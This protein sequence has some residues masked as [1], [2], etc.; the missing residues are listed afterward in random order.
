[1]SAQLASRRMVEARLK[2]H[3]GRRTARTPI[4]WKAGR[5]MPLRDENQPLRVVQ[6]SWRERNICLRRR[7]VLSGCG[8]AL[9]KSSFLNFFRL[10]L[11]EGMKRQKAPARDK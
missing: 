8:V 3:A 1:M 2:N 10:Q 7:Q 5:K 6:I 9:H 11:I 4:I